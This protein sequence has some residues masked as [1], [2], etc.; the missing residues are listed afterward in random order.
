MSSEFVVRSLDDL[1]AAADWLLGEMGEEKLLG[2][3][4]DLGSGKTTLVAQILKKLG[5]LDPVQSPT[6]SIVN[7][8]RDEHGNPVY[9]IDLYRLKDASELS[10]LGL[11][12]MMD[13]DAFCFIEWPEIAKA[14]FPAESLYLRISNIDNEQRKLIIFKE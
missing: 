13:S 7:E 5:S 10:G 4:G 3:I 2:L 8:Y 1:P 14:L 9:H 6:Y 12:E 11:E